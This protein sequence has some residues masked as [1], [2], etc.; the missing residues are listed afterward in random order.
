MKPT[1]DMD[2]LI[3][4]SLQE[5]ATRDEERALAA[6][7][8]AAA[9]N[10]AY[11][12]EQRQLWE[13]A[14]TT[15]HAAGAPPQPRARDLVART[16]AEQAGPALMPRRR[17]RW[18]EPLAA[19]AVVLG[20]LLGGA[21]FLR[22]AAEPAPYFG[23]AEFATG[24]REFVTVRLDDGTIVRLGPSSNLQLDGSG[25]QRDVWLEGDAFFAVARH[26][27]APFVVRTRAGN[28]RVLGTRFDLH[29]RNEDLRVV[30]VD[31]R[32][33][34]ESGAS[35]QHEEVG[36]NEVSHIIGGGRPYVTQVPDVYAL[37]EWMKNALVFQATPLDRVAEELEHRY[38]VPVEL[39]DPAV[40]G[41][42]ITAW[43]TDE[44]LDA[45][46][47]VIC[48]VAEVRCTVSENIV[49]IGL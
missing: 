12:E 27:N 5:R 20:L 14:A 42:T 40:A 34:V 29:A 11:Y 44:P 18:Y 38:G 21:L 6:W 37:L 47:G 35:G 1:N 30:V 13:L 45:A 10:R 8:E 22:E 48:R 24:A 33:R 3:V 49:R 16:A 26:D 41:R 28:A 23:V 2:E 43:F 19:A 7:L 36:P 31:G 32:V 15:S 9:D 17:L 25:G 39:A 4:R 46:I